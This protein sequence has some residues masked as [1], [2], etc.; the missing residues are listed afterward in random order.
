MPNDC[1]EAL[2]TFVRM[3]TP[4]DNA[5]AYSAGDLLRELNQRGFSGRGFKAVAIGRAM[6]NMGFESKKIRGTFKYSVVLADYDRQKRERI[7]D[8]IPED[9]KPF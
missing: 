1:E 8:A 4:I 5:E 7:D 2:R 6:K 9:E 3:P